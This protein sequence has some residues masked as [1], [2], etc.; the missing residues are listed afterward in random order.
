MKDN[1][2]VIAIDEDYE[3]NLERN[4]ISLTFDDGYKDN[5]IALEICE[6]YDIPFTLY[7]TTGEIGKENYLDKKEILEFAKSDKC[8]LGSHSHTHPLL[9]TLSFEE[10]YRELEISKKILEDITGA[11]IV[12]ISYPHGS[13]T[14]DTLKI[15]RELGYKIVASSN[16]GINSKNNIDP[17][18]VKR[19]EIVA[20]DDVRFLRKKILGYYDY[21]AWKE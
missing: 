19:I 17:L 5:L 7:I 12:G 20:T 11:S 13:Y 1:H 15:A 16:I 14:Q 10:Q 4:T 8:I 6:K 9:A 18:E 21:L 3:N 2:E